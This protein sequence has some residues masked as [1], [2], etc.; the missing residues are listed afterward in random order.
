[1]SR[2]ACHRSPNSFVVN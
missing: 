2:C 1:V